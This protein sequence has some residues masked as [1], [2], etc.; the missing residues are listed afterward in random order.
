MQRRTKENN[1]QPRSWGETGTEKHNTLSDSDGAIWNG[2]GGKGDG[3]TWVLCYTGEARKASRR[4]D[5]EQR[6]E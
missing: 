4:G 6:P 1:V 3:V 5:I 2:D